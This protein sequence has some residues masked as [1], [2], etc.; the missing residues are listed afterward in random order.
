MGEG[1]AREVLLLVGMATPSK[2][3]LFLST[4]FWASFQTTQSLS[5]GFS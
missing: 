2:I 3:C 5:S 4:A 1:V